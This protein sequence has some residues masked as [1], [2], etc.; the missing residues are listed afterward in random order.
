MLRAAVL[1]AGLALAVA[2]AA[3]AWTL[4][5]TDVQHIVVPS[6]IVTQPVV[7]FGERWTT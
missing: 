6:L 3:G 7:P 5:A 1:A 4:L 2:P